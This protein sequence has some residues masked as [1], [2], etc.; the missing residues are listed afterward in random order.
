MLDELLYVIPANTA[1]EEVKKALEAHPEIKFVSLVG[2]D[3]A[4][5]FLFERK[6][7]LRPVPLV[8]VIL[9]RMFHDFVRERSYD[10]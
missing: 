1:R 9:K 7:G 2:I 3:M 8:G 4:D 5:P 6:S 10:L